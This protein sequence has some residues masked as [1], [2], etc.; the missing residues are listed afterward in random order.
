[1]EALIF[2]LTTIHVRD[3]IPAGGVVKKGDVAHPG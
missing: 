2:L 1:M 3:R